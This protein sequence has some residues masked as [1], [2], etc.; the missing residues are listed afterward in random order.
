M[1]SLTRERIF[2]IVAKSKRLPVEAL[3]LDTTFDELGIDS[4]DAI[5]IV[6]E[7][8]E[9]FNMT[10]SDDR[11]HSL[12]A[13]RDLVEMLQEQKEIVHPGDRHVYPQWPWSFLAMIVRTAFLEGIAMPLVA[14]LAAPRVK[15][16]WACEPDKPI[17][18][19]ANHVTVFDVPLLFYAL[20]TKMRRRVAI[21]SVGEFL[22]DLRQGRGPY[23]WFIN[24]A[25]YYMVTALFNVFPLP[26][27]G[28]FRAS[29]AH[30][31]RA[32]RRG[33]HVLIFAEGSRTE[34]GQIQ[35]FQRGSGLL[36]TELQCSALPVY[37]GGLWGAKGG[38]SKWFRSGRIYTHV[39]APITLGPIL[40]SRAATGRLEEGV[41]NL[42]LPDCECAD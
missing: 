19:V 6:F 25:H 30:A 20:G 32:M 31:A 37:L 23:N 35:V 13:M 36:W 28:D 40:E 27:A 29:F 41:R 38:L 33:F 18:I 11:V 1:D 26:Q 12:R 3:T 10:V 22:S 5:G 2:K 42:R 34:N 15:K 7:V 9:E 4:V 14:L 17:L 24:R 16:D 8:E 39:G 21:A